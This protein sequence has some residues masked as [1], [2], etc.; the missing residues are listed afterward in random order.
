LESGWRQE[1]RDH[2]NM[3]P[4]R[5][6]HTVFHDRDAGLSELEEARPGGNQAPPPLFIVRIAA[7]KATRGIAFAGKSV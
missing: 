3:S 7:G 6:C 5:E 1:Q 2:E 4:Q